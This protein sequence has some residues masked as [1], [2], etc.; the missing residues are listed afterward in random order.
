VDENGKAVLG[1]TDR[2][3]ASDAGSGPGNQCCP[4]VDIGVELMG[5]NQVLLAS[6]GFRKGLCMLA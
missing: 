4:G 3:R 2:D 1:E 5:S 6:S